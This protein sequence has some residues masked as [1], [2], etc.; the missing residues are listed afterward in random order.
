M[1][2]DGEM[3]G[4]G[5]FGSLSHAAIRTAVMLGRGPAVEDHVD[6]CCGSVLDAGTHH[7]HAKNPAW[8]GGPAYKGRDALQNDAN[9]NRAVFSDLTRCS[10]PQRPR[11]TASRSHDG[12]LFAS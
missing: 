12:F 9:A 3:T 5:R 7:A 8:S 4:A 2:D 11:R 1:F 6:A 10:V